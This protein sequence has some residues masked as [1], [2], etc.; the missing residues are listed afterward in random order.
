MRWSSLFLP[1]VVLI[2]S[3]VYCYPVSETDGSTEQGQTDHTISPSSNSSSVDP[4]SFTKPN[5]YFKRSGTR[6]CGVALRDA[7]RQDC[8]NRPGIQQFTFAGAATGTVV[9]RQMTIAPGNNPPNTVQCEHVLELQVA[10]HVLLSS[11]F[12]DVLTAFR[13][14]VGQ[15]AQS[16]AE[17]MEGIVAAINARNNLFFLQT[18]VNKSK[19]T[20]VQKVLS[21]AVAVP[22]LSASSTPTNSLAFAD[23]HQF[24]HSPGVQAA[25]TAV[26]NAADV[27]I[28]AVIARANAVQN[29]PAALTAALAAFNGHVANGLTVAATWNR[30]LAGVV[31]A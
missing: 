1:F 20:Y 26:A 24:I 7:D 27:A 21:N 5:N 29:A 10:Q 28:N 30:V 19:A 9:A 23:V 25:S 18:D 14:A 16:A 4:R 17:I 31:V 3:N 12:C 6:V 15:G 2:A 13:A 11:G 22:Q 8:I